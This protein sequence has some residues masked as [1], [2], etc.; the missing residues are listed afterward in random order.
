MTAAANGLSVTEY[1]THTA[2]RLFVERITKCLHD[3]PGYARIHSVTATREEWTVE[4]GLLTPTLKVKRPQVQERYADSIAAMY[5]EEEPQEAKPGV[6][7]AA[8]AAD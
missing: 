4:N 7:A 5:H 8:G 3:F 1:D 2:E 6:E